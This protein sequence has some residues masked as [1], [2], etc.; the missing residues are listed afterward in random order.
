MKRLQKYNK[1]FQAVQKDI[2]FFLMFLSLISHAHPF[3]AIKDCS[4]LTIMTLMYDHSAKPKYSAFKQAL[5]GHLD[6]AALGPRDSNSVVI[7]Q[8]WYTCPATGSRFTYDNHTQVTKLTGEINCL[9]WALALMG[10]V[11]D[12]IDNYTKLHGPVPLTVPN[13][14]FV[15]SVLAVAEDTH[16]TVLLE[17]VIDDAMD[18]AFVKYIGNGSAQPYNFLEEDA[19]D[20]AKFLSFA[21][22]LQYM[23][24]D[25][26]AF[27]SDF[28]GTLL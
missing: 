22:H 5:F 9:R 25:G 2:P 26:L 14:H 12:H 7:K 15:K 23:K 20:R 8:C 10:L 19:I 27:V 13:M 6:C 28:Q 11:Y 3:D 1:L 16:D 24:T 4:G 18:G 17:E 21:Q